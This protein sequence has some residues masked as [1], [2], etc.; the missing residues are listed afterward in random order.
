MLCSFQRGFTGGEAQRCAEDKAGGAEEELLTV[1]QCNMLFKG[2]VWEAG[3]RFPS[4]PISLGARNTRAFD[5]SAAALLGSLTP[6]VPLAPR[7]G[8]CWREKGPRVVS[9]SPMPAAAQPW[10]NCFCF[11][12][13]PRPGECSRNGLSSV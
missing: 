3:G 9:G 13:L 7:P 4:V 11:F 8:G 2:G 5:T 10:A 6:P 1:C 12:S